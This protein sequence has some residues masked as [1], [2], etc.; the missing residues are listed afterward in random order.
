MLDG[1]WI[2]LQPKLAKR[3]SSKKTSVE[4]VR[5]GGAWLINSGLLWQ[6]ERKVSNQITS[7]TL[8][9]V[10]IDPLL[11]S[12][13][14]N[15]LRHRGI[16]ALYLDRLNNQKLLDAKRAARPTVS[17]QRQVYAVISHLFVA[18]DS[19]AVWISATFP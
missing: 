15:G 6:A 12:L 14:P 7:H 10:F 2:S 19:F 5:F 17:P 3:V 18:Q 9:L 8:I 1:A 4:T 13:T 11:F 16:P